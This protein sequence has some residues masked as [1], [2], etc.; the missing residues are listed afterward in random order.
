MSDLSPRLNLPYLL[1]GQAQKHVTVNEALLRLDNLVHL[2]VISRNI[3]TPPETPDAEDRYLVPVG[4]IGDWQHHVGDIAYHMDDTWQ[5]LTPHTGWAIWISSETLFAIFDGSDWVSVGSGEHV[6]QLGIGTSPDPTNRLA[7]QLNAALFTAIAVADGG[8][9]N[10]RIVINRENSSDTASVLFQTGFVAGGEIGQMGDSGLRLKAFNASEETGAALHLDGGTGRVAVEGDLI[11]SSFNGAALAGDRNKI[12]NGGFNIWQ[13]GEGPFDTH[14]QFNADRWLQ[15][16][17]PAFASSAVQ[18]QPVETVPG[19]TVS[20]RAIRADINGAADFQ[21]RQK[22]LDV[23]TLAGKSAAL[24]L[25]LRADAGRDLRV[26]GQQ[27]F[28]AG[29]SSPQTV[30]DV[31]LTTGTD[32]A[33]VSTLFDFPTLLGKTIGDGSHIVLVFR[34]VDW[35]SGSWFEMTDV[36]LEEGVSATRFGERHEAGELQLCR[37]F[38]RRQATAQTIADLA[39]DMRDTPTETGTGPY[40]YDAEL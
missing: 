36:Q 11:A 20:G 16:G 28:G 26:L 10:V 21:L 13:R 2:S 22:I 8:S 6:S 37:H 19:K 30:F 15:L 7:A 14:N 29:G 18:T 39:Y 17:S 24:S 1:P 32:W 31:T 34:A 9:G 23:R 35:P 5:F 4:A 27:W 40:D 25:A 33:A 3:F 38:F 12:I